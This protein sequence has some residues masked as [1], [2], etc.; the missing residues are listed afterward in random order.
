[1]TTEDPSPPSPPVD[2]ATR[3]AAIVHDLQTR[4][5]PACADWPPE[6]FT[7]MVERLADITLRYE[8][9]SSISTYDRRTTE[10]LVADLK[11]ALQREEKGRDREKE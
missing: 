7:S 2:V 8:G 1:M 10:R 4:L 6:L 11:Q 3:L 9:R 5:G